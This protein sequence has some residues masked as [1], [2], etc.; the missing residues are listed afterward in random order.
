MRTAKNDR[1]GAFLSNRKYSIGGG[2]YSTQTTLGD[3]SKP[4]SDYFANT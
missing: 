3:C 1:A 4:S 2:N